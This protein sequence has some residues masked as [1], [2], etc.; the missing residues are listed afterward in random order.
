MDLEG[1]SAN[2][3]IFMKRS[4]DKEELKLQYIKISTSGK[5]VFSCETKD[6]KEYKVYLD[7]TDDEKKKI[8]LNRM[9][10]H[11]SP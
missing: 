9:T 3:E 11:I 5:I 6:G 1:L 8:T 7:I 10:D 2:L 4:L